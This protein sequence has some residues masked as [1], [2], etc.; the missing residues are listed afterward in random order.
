MGPVGLAV[1]AP[2]ADGIGIRTLFF[3]SGVVFLA[4]ALTWALTPSVRDLEQGPPEGAGT[5]ASISQAQP[6]PDLL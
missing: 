6:G 3:L 4:V 2:L 5:A 1:L